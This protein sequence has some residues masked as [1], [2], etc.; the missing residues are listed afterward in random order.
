MEAIHPQRAGTSSGLGEVSKQACPK[1][2]RDESCFLN[3]LCRKAPA[4][5][6]K[7]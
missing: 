4:K 2:K 1:G 7:S 6:M 3:Q 5:T